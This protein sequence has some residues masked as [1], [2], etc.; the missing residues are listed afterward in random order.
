MAQFGSG[1]LYR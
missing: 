1:E